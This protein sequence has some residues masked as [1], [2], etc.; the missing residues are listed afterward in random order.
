MRRDLDKHMDMIT[1]KCTVDDDDAQF[2]ADLPDDFPPLQP[3]LPVQHLEP[4]F[5]CPDNPDNMVTMMKSL[6]AP[7]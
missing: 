1:R 3:Y 5:C 4:V 7:S 6:V 2:A